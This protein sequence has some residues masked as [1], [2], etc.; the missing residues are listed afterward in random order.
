MAEEEK[1]QLLAAEK[2]KLHAIEVKKQV[3]KHV[4]M[5]IYHV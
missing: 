1:I 4:T 2:R 3:M 5:V